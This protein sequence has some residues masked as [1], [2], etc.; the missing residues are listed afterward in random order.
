MCTGSVAPVGPIT[1]NREIRQYF[2][3]TTD[4]F[5]GFSIRFATYAQ[6]KSS[7]VTVSLY[8]A[9]DNVLLGRDTFSAAILK[10]NAYKRVYFTEQTDT[11]GKRYYL[12]VESDAELQEDAITIWTGNIPENDNDMLLVVDGQEQ[13]TAFVMSYLFDEWHPG[14]EIFMLSALFAVLVLFVLFYD[15]LH[16]SRE[17][18]VLCIYFLSLLF[19]SWKSFFYMTQIEDFPDENIHVAYIMQQKE[20]KNF[21]PDFFSMRQFSPGTASPDA[22]YVKYNASER[23]N[24]LGHPPIYYNILALAGDSYIEDGAYYVNITQFRLLSFSIA[25]AA[26]ILVFYLGYS[27]LKKEPFLHLLYAVICIGIPMHSYISAGVNND[28]LSFLGVAVFAWGALRFCESKKN[29]STFF[30]IAS[31]IGIACMAKLTAGVLVL[32]ATVLFLLI[33]LFFTRDFKV[34]VSKAFLFTL[35]VYALVAAYFIWVYLTVGAF[36]PTYKVINPEQFLISEFYV[37]VEQ[38]MSMTFVEYIG[39]FIEYFFG[40][41]IGIASHGIATRMDANLSVLP[42]IWILPAAGF[43]YMRKK[44]IRDQIFFFSMYVSALFWVGMQLMSAYRGF[45]ETSGYMGGFQSRYYLCASFGFAFLIARLFQSWEEKALE[46][47]SIAEDVSDSFQPAGEG[48]K[49]IGLKSFFLSRH[50]CA[51][52]AILFCGCIFYED[53]ILF[54]LYVG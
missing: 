16:I 6:R 51:A 37:P 19:F 42:M 22:R 53:F 7:S 40:T 43:L 8:D 4:R 18:V 49:G 3:A 47:K 17:T 33:Y 50:V 23:T 25:L 46:Q 21:L 52:V 44:K 41:W 13:D 30:L 28:T 9:Q 35:P 34:F 10:D 24:Y 26:Q 20:D 5:Q 45:S 38:R 36:Q 32:F 2:T 31:G 11:R 54:L 15:R 1:S 12:H 48:Q 27:R 39:Y 14:P 29:Y